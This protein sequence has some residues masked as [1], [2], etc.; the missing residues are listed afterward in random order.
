MRVMQP[1]TKEK[2]FHIDDIWFKVFHTLFT[3]FAFRMI[4]NDFDEGG[5]DF[6][7]MENIIRQQCTIFEPHHAS[8]FVEV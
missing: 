8:Y 6:Y 1:L 5:E 4:I 7:T 2:Q 3:C